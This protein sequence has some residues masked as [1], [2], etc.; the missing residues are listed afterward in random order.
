[1]RQVWWNG[2]II[3]EGEARI[4][5]YDSALMFGDTVFEML[6]TFKGKPFKVREHLERLLLGL[7]FI[8]VYV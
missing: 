2:K 5:I 4:S 8:L 1:M 7:I 3:P 6:R